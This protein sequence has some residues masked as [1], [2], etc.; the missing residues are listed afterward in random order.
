MYKDNHKVEKT[1]KHIKSAKKERSR[2]HNKICN[3]FFIC[4]VMLS[5]L[6]IIM[7]AFHNFL[8]G[9]LPRKKTRSGR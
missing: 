8:E 5:A 4:G 1:T 2:W 3:F 9:E 7:P 6:V